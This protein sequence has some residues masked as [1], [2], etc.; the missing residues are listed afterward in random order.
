VTRDGE[1]VEQEE[2]DVGNQ[3]EDEEPGLRHVDLSDLSTSDNDALLSPAH[4]QKLSGNGITTVNELF[5]RTDTVLERLMLARGIRESYVR[6][7]TWRRLAGIMQLPNMTVAQ[8]RRLLFFG[9]D[10]LEKVASCRPE[11][12]SLPWGESDTSRP[13]ASDVQE[14]LSIAREQYPDMQPIDRQTFRQTASRIVI[15]GHEFAIAAAVLTTV[16]SI[17]GGLVCHWSISSQ[18]TALHSEAVPAGMSRDLWEETTDEVTE[19]LCTVKSGLYLL[20]WG[21]VGIFIGGMYLVWGLVYLL[22]KLW[23][24]GAKLSDDFPDKVVYDAEVVAFEGMFNSIRLRALLRLRRPFWVFFGGIFIIGVGM[25]T[26]VPDPDVF[27]STDFSILGGVFSAALCAVVFSYYGLSGSLPLVAAQR[28]RPDLRSRL[29]IRNWARML[30]STLLVTVTLLAAF[31]FFGAFGYGVEKGT[32]YWKDWAL[33]R[34]VVR[35]HTSCTQAEAHLVR[36]AKSDAEQ[37]AVERLISEIRPGLTV[38]PELPTFLDFA[39]FVPWLARLFWFIGTPIVLSCVC[40]ALIP[41]FASSPPLLTVTIGAG[42]FVAEY[43]AGVHIESFAVS[44]SSAGWIAVVGMAVS[45]GVSLPFKAVAAL[46]Q[47]V[48]QKGDHTDD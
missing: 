16:L 18:D 37:K 3:Q 33:E 5:D 2:Q 36:V 44:H 21:W 15:T 46:L 35:V 38:F 4:L 19:L 1:T 12:L 13:Q 9:I 39:E 34:T 24:F 11:W 27:R 14:W 28:L 47:P 40:L 17:M 32:R 26:G 43:F 31:V 25:L 6:V 22:G 23:D 41:H 10:S 45:Y 8:A 42:L 29:V 7:S 20:L 30:I 48:S